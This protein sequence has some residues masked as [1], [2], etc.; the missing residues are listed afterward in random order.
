MNGESEAPDGPVEVVV[1]DFDG[2]LVDSVD[3]KTRAFVA[4]Y[5]SYGPQVA[6]QVRAHHLA[7]G[8]ISRYVKFEY[9]ERVLL[10]REPT[11]ERLEE[12]ADAFAR[13]VV[14]QVVAAPEVPGASGLLDELDG[15]VPLHVASGTP[16]VELL[17]IVRRRGW[18]GHF[19]SV[20]GTPA[21]KAE[22][23]SGISAEWAVDPSRMLMI[24]DA[25]TDLD[26]AWA[27]G[28]QFVGLATEGDPFPAGTRV[29]ASL[30]EVGAIIRGRIA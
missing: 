8:G 20:R 30:G 15:R 17:E 3:V 29:V 5:E 9:Y 21:T 6:E 22:I 27:A 12:L 7:H 4:L 11:R 26:G 19:E 28:T 10:G 2:V 18:D 24:G 14:D 23:L 1:F 13:L 25:T 16:E